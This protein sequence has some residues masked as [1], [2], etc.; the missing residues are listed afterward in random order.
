M[1]KKLLEK[2]ERRLEGEESSSSSEW[3]SSDDEDS[4]EEVLDAA[5]LPDWLKDIKETEEREKKEFWTER[6]RKT[7]TLQMY[8]LPER[9]MK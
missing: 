3:S 4:D 5:E 7:W 6:T 9:K 8:H 2:D 1:A